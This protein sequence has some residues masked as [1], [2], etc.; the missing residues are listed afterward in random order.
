MTTYWLMSRIRE[1]RIKNINRPEKGNI[2]P[3]TR[4]R[5]RGVAEYGK[6]DKRR[7]KGSEISTRCRINE[8]AGLER[9]RG[10]PRVKVEREV[11]MEMEV[12]GVVPGACAPRLNLLKPELGSGAP[13]PAFEETA[14]RD[15]SATKS[16]P[17]RLTGSEP[18]PE[19]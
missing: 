4:I 16:V 14:F 8:P 10:A 18:L 13:F 11:A 12:E 15:G 3:S 19:T 9:L 5:R 2:Y 6:R 7:E 1:T 17:P